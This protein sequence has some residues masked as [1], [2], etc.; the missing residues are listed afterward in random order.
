M[1]IQQSIKN[2]TRQGYYLDIVIDDDGLISAG[3]Y[4][5]PQQ[6][7]GMS[8]SVLEPANEVVHEL[9]DVLQ[10]VEKRLQ[11]QLTREKHNV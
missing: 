11:K 7:S 5:K 8:T 4:T 6:P 1:G 2:I 3:L 10:A 9:I